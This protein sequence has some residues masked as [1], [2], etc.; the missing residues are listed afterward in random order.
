MQESDRMKREAAEMS[1]AIAASRREEEEKKAAER[2]RRLEEE[3]AEAKL[4]AEAEMRA[5]IEASRLEEEEK[6]AAEEARVRREREGAVSRATERA[7]AAI[8]GLCARAKE[9]LRVELR[10]QKRL[11]AGKER[12]EMIL[13]GG[14]ERKAGLVAE[15]EALDGSMRELELWLAAVR[16]EQRRR[17]SATRADNGDD[18]EEGKR[19]DEGGDETGGVEPMASSATRADLVAVPADTRSAQMLALSAE[20]AAIDDC[21]YFLD[22]ALVHGS[23]TLEVFLKEVRRLSNRQFLAKVNIQARCRDARPSFSL[24]AMPFP[25]DGSPRFLHSSIV[26]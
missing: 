4:A 22:K 9:E 25:F 10:D 21:V 7:R 15:N 18:D 5:A 20:S 8:G 13:R 3:A 12:I 6:K 24:S 14:E 11:E 1:E 23:L 26:P 17:R 19:R 2:L 16:D